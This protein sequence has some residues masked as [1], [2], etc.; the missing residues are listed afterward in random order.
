MFRVIFLIMSYTP[1]GTI[2]DNKPMTLSIT[3]GY[4][5]SIFK[6]VHLKILKTN[7]VSDFSGNHIG[8][9]GHPCYSRE[10]GTT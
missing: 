8:V 2:P 9:K 10:W 6:Y 5:G 3:E 4:L 7:I 1:E